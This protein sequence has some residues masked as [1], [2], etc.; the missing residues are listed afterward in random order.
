MR[1]KLLTGA[2]LA[3]IIFIVALGFFYSIFI[4]VPTIENFG[5]AKAAMEKYVVYDHRETIYCGAK[6]DA[7]KRI[8]AAPGFQP[9]K[10]NARARRMEW[11][12]AVPAV[13]FGGELPAWKNGHPECINP[14]SR[15]PFRGRKCAERVEKEFR[16]MEADLY[17]LFP[18]IGAVNPVRGNRD[19]AELPTEPNAF[20]ACA[21]KAKG[22]HFEPPD[23]AKGQV[24]R[25]SLYMAATYPAR[26]KPEAWQTDLFEAWNRHFPVDE[27]ECERAKR[28]ARL[29]KRENEFI[30]KPCVAAGLW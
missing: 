11:E 18:V 12:H 4:Y 27:W 28:I 1:D 8:L 30:K 7:E 24:A 2:A 26:Y 22:S 21:A 3:G 13:K 23:R 19:Y 29:Q 17:N 15:K 6:F 25:A 9:K 20:G 14:R 16:D 10:E 5:D